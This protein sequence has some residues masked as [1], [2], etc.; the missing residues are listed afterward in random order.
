MNTTNKAQSATSKAKVNAKNATSKA[1]A[2]QANEAKKQADKEAKATAKE[3]EKV[4]NKRLTD[5]EKIAV[6]TL[7]DNFFG[8]FQ[9]VNFL[10]AEII[11]AEKTDEILYKLQNVAKGLKTSE[12]K[13]AILGLLNMNQFA[14][15]ATNGAKYSIPLVF[16]L[17]K[18]YDKI[19]PELRHEVN[20]RGQKFNDLLMG[21]K[22]GI[23]TFAQSMDAFEDVTNTKLTVKNLT[24]ATAK[25][26]FNLYPQK[27]RS[28]KLIEKYD[29]Q[30]EIEK[31]RISNLA[32]ANKILTDEKERI[33]KLKASKGTKVA[34]S[35]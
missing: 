7:K 6:L 35:A 12:D 8:L 31:K 29:E 34:V 14:K 2:K 22:N 20:E 11:N 26:Y 9:V 32:K 15:L 25:I 18:T 21:A 16:N 24:K 33:F 28:L 4:E 5:L 10:K 19:K 23:F 17:F 27:F 3:A 13:K 30:V 1:K